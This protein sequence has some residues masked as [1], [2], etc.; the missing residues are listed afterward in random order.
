MSKANTEKETKLGNTS[1]L[2]GDVVV[3]WKHGT[4]VSAK[5]VKVKNE[6]AKD[7]LI[8][9]EKILDVKLIKHNDIIVFHT[10]NAIHFR[11]EKFRKI[12]GSER[13]ADYYVDP[14]LFAFYRKDI[15]GYWYD[16]EGARVISTFILKGDVLTSLK[17]KTTVKNAIFRDQKLY[18]SPDMELVQIGKVVLDEYLTAVT[19]QGQRV[20]SL[21][22]SAV[23]FE[24][25]TV[26]QGIKL[27]INETAM[28]N[29]KT[30]EPIVINGESLMSFINTVDLGNNKYHVFKSEKRDHYLNSKNAKPINVQEK[31]FSL[32]PS[33]FIQL[34][35]FE[36]VAIKTKDSRYFYDLKHDTP[37]QISELGDAYITKA[38]RSNV[39]MENVELINISTKKKS[40]VVKSNDLSIYTGQDDGLDIEKIKNVPGFEGIF[41]MVTIKGKQHLYSLNTEKVIYVDNL[42]IVGVEGHAKNKLLNAVASNGERVVIDLRRGFNDLNFALSDGDYIIQTMSEPHEIGSKV[43]QNVKIQTLGG[44]KECVIDL[45]SSELSTF[46]FPYDM[47]VFSDV[48][49]VFA[50]TPLVSIDF[51]KV[52]TIKSKKFL[53]AKFRAY[54]DTLHTAILDHTNGRPVQ[55][56]GLGHRSE[57]VTGFLDYSLKSVY[58]LG[59]HRMI[60]VSTLKEDL[61]PDQLL[62]SIDSMTSWL[63]FSDGYLP[64]FKKVVEVDD[65]GAW[66]YHLFELRELSKDKEYIAVEQIKPNR[67]L[68]QK[69]G[70]KNVPIVVQSKEKILKSP[71][72]ISM[73]RKLFFEDPGV[74]QEVY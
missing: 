69:K 54:D 2:I 64:I 45:N 16:M 13:W 1:K 3:T 4:F 31:E 14:F 38:A 24:N 62:I 28:I 26:Y 59:N 25:G 9:N 10:E 6:K 19:Y 53:T 60:G 18:T 37:F 63:P 20:T 46:T 61:K 8:D 11:N 68:V 66:D 58:K 33:S 43:L 23:K 15:K 47:V 36:I 55:M 21:D 57:I 50:R 49:S 48:K 32:Y 5:Q 71:E 41:A 73:I 27:G 40:V 7:Y 12:R 65:V 30:K 39:P 52:I 56:D 67:I 70:K 29:E 42:S 35:E 74:L 17:G 72:E 44:N 34:D 22:N 51:E